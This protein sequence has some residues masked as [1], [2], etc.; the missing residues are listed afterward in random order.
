[1]LG[2]RLNRLTLL[3]GEFSRVSDARAIGPKVGTKTQ[4]VTGEIRNMVNGITNQVEMATPTENC[5]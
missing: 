5:S 1:M 3:V 2:E 4:V